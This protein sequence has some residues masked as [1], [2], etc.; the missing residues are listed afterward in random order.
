MISY[1]IATTTYA[2]V[3]RKG[4]GVIG[5]TSNL[6]QSQFNVVSRKCST[7]IKWRSLTEKNK[8]Q[9]SS[10]VRSSFSPSEGCINLTDVLRQSEKKDAQKASSR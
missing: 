6:H 4:G 1:R 7:P 8:H 5:V 10:C 2:V 9:S 3:L